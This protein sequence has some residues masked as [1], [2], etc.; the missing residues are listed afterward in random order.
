MADPI[1]HETIIKN[2]MT[3]L[4]N[5]TMQAQD[6]INSQV[7]SNGARDMLENLGADA[8]ADYIEA[9]NAY[10]IDTFAAF[11]ALS[12]DALTSEQKSLRNLIYAESYFSLYYLAIALKKLVKGAVNTTRDS[13]SGANIWSAPFDDIIANADNYR[14]LANQCLGFATSNATEEPDDIYSQGQFGV[15]TV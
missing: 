12:F 8:Y 6:R 4:A 15:F 14:D 7:L 13:A 2:T 3:L 5:V 10:D 11:E 1:V 9:L